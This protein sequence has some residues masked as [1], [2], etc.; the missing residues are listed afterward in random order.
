MN[1]A[2]KTQQRRDRIHVNTLFTTSEEA[3][4]LHCRNKHTYDAKLS[5]GEMMSPE[6]VLWNRAGV[7]ANVA[8]MPN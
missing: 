1:T 2:F 4:S 6:P 8:N 5:H 3:A 7:I